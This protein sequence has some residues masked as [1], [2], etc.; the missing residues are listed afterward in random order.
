MKLKQIFLSVFAML[1]FLNFNLQKLDA[2]SA[3][4]NSVTNETEYEMLFEES[5]KIPPQ[6]TLSSAPLPATIPK[7]LPGIA[8]EGTGK[9]VEPFFSGQVIDLYPLL[10]RGWG[11][12]YEEYQRGQV[13]VTFQSKAESDIRIAFHDKF[14]TDPMYVVSI[15]GEGN[16]RSYILKNG[17]EKAYVTRE[18]NPDAMVS[19]IKGQEAGAFIPF[20]ICYDNG[21]ILVGKG[22][23][24]DNIFL[25]WKDPDPN[26][27][28][29]KIGLGSNNKQV[30]YT[31]VLLLPPVI[32][33][34]PKEFYDSIAPTGVKE[35]AQQKIVVDDNF[36]QYGAVVQIK[37]LQA[38]QGLK[39]FSPSPKVIVAGDSDWWIIKGRNGTPDSYKFGEKIRNGSV[40]RLENLGLRKNLNFNGTD[41]EVLGK[42]GVGDVGDNWIVQIEGGKKTDFWNKTSSFNL[43]NQQIKDILTFTG[44][45]FVTTV[46]QPDQ[47]TLWQVSNNQA[48]ITNKELL[49]GSIIA[50]KTTD[51]KYLTVQTLEG[52]FKEPLRFN[53]LV[54]LKNTKEFLQKGRSSRVDNYLV[55]DGATSVQALQEKQ[56]WRIVSSLNPEAAQEIRFGD[57]V[58]LQSTFGKYL[59]KI[60]GRRRVK[61]QL[62]P[63]FE[64]VGKNTSFVIVDPKNPLNRGLVYKGN[65]VAFES[66]DK[67]Y[68]SNFADFNVAL[69]PY[70]GSNES[71]K[72]VEDVQSKKDITTRVFA[73]NGKVT[74]KNFATQFRIIR[75]GGEIGFES[76]FNNQNLT[77]SKKYGWNLSTQDS[78]DF[79]NRK[80]KSEKFLLRKVGDNY[81]LLS[82]GTLG[83]VNY[84]GETGVSDNPHGYSRNSM[85]NLQLLAKPKIEILEARY[86]SA[87]NVFDV[88]DIVQSRVIGSTLIIP[89]GQEAK[90][91]LFGDPVRGKEKTLTITYREEGKQPFKV[92]VIDSQA[93]LLGLPEKFN[94]T[95]IVDLDSGLNGAYFWLP[96]DFRVAGRGAISFEANAIDDIYIAFSDGKEP[97]WGT[98]KQFY[99]IVIGD[100]DNSRVTLRKRSRS[101]QLAFSSTPGLIPQ[102]G[103]FHKYWI[104]INNGI[105][106]VG[107]GEL[108]QEVL[109]ACKDL[110]PLL[111]IN[112]I[113]ISNG[114]NPVICKN[115]NFA[116]PVDIG[117]APGLFEEY[118]SEYQTYLEKVRKLIFLTPFKYSIYHKDSKQIVLKDEVGKQVPIAETSQK[119]LKDYPFSITINSAGDPTPLLE[120]MPEETGLRKGL[121]FG[122]AMLSSISGVAGA[123]PD[124]RAQ[125]AGAAG[126]ALG[127][128]AGLVSDALGGGVTG[129]RVEQYSRKS[130]TVYSDPEIMANNQRIQALMAN[131]KQANPQDPGQ[132]KYMIDSYRELILLIISVD[133]VDAV[134]KDRIFQ[135]LRNLIKY[136]TMHSPETYNSLINMLLKAHNNRFLF[137]FEGDETKRNYIFAGLSDV[138]KTLY[139]TQNE[140]EIEELLGEYLWLEQELPDLGNGSIEFEV[141][142]EKDIFVAFSSEIGKIRETKKS[143]QMY[144]LIIGTKNNT[145]SIFRL[146]NKGYSIPGASISSNQK[147]EAVLELGKYRKYWFSIKTTSQNGRNKSTLSFGYDAMIPEN[148]LLSW[149]DTQP[150]K[151]IKYVGIGSW[152]ALA[153]IKDIKIGPPQGEIK[154]ENMYPI[155]E[156]ARA[157][158]PVY[159]EW[160][161]HWNKSKQE[162][163]MQQASPAA[164]QPLAA[165]P[166]PIQTKVA[167]PMA[168]L[169]IFSKIWDSIF[170]RKREA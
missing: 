41:V 126:Q 102:D 77:A 101:S 143:I 138:A 42:S 60:S 40:V 91:L 30:Q 2:Q 44:G 31:N 14:S 16:T 64:K 124:P 146:E 52:M 88:T 147:P 103:K 104:S 169:N 168:K 43:V 28:I 83:V 9:R 129:V 153:R 39:V 67:T 170:P 1:L 137:T 37:N 8:I 96:Y 144:E 115:F 100:K 152:E 13:T 133:N 45:T 110:D 86:G 163:M 159:Q 97:V 61:N 33:F 85:F 11:W 165:Q 87:E 35:E 66:A 18:E 156:G 94:Q 106:L 118:Q 136:H 160:V 55:A 113:G 128:V 145:A 12:L 27:Y 50:L 123:I 116:P 71:W 48:P 73:S 161:K 19:I 125:I 107:K 22:W 84:L 79:Y 114:R 149:T 121:K 134:L 139:R 120:W 93:L 24:G 49:V 81:F 76:L 132:F 38:A 56:R 21:L 63:A 127:Q 164:T 98:D 7:E 122:G 10:G 78:A 59:G 25:S 75:Q 3:E 105:V 26:P 62:A 36:L 54:L 29:N 151:N 68:I 82:L 69:K 32:T 95:G 20:W 131:I 92:D 141:D 140:V 47:Y 162:K 6:K 148:I 46:K 158:A 5:V 65:E 70:M 99:E 4:L 90:V 57:V 119:G 154:E 80:N 157:G 72:I 142:G 117:G 109:L 34:P 89:I 130:P 155:W 111:N 112:S 108:G 23:P 53:D 15:G 58:T 166:V 51:N 150:F 17:S 74:S 135:D 167:K